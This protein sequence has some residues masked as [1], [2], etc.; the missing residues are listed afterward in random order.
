MPE[1]ELSVPDGDYKS[2]CG[3]CRI[4]SVP[5]GITDPSAAQQKRLFCTDC[6]KTCGARIASE[7]DLSNCKVEDGANIYN[8]NGVLA[9]REPLPPNQDNLPAGSF[10]SS[11]HGCSVTKNTLKCTACLDEAKERH[12]S[13]IDFS[14]CKWLGNNHGK[15]FC[16]DEPEGPEPKPARTSIGGSYFSSCRGCSVAG[17]ILTCDSCKNGNDHDIPA[18]LDISNCRSVANSAGTLHCTDA[19]AEY[20]PS[21]SDLER[22]YNDKEQAIAA[23]LDVEAPSSTSRPD[24]EDL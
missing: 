10:S 2:S 12:V 22:G 11:C 19:M 1:N 3:G 15:L 13:S 23:E 21:Q 9:C 24:R 20:V 14:G 6:T 5:A 18:R 7:I 4:Q 17:D 16:V 8:S